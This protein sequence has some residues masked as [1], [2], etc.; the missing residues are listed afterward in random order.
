MIGEELKSLTKM[1]MQH[2][3]N[4]PDIYNIRNNNLIWTLKN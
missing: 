4:K 2:I 1:V 3:S